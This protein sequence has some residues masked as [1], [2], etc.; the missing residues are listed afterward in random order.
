M[1]V[2]QKVNT[3]KAAHALLL[4]LECS[5]GFATMMD[6]KNAGPDITAPLEQ[7]ILKY[8]LQVNIVLQEVLIM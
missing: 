6:W 8:V 2:A 4:L 7:S 5:L 3:M 1:D